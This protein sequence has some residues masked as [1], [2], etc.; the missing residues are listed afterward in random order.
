MKPAT[1]TRGEVVPIQAPVKHM[2]EKPSFTMCT[3]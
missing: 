3:F 1:A 2:G